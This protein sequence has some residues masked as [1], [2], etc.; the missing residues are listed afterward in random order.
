M[1]GMEL[2]IR[3]VWN[4][5]PGWLSLYTGGFLEL[6]RCVLTE[7][8]PWSPLLIGHAL[9]FTGGRGRSSEMAARPVHTTSGRF[10]A[11]SGLNT[12]RSYASQSPQ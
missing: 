5:R 12:V 8:C 4:P 3:Y 1:A 6:A 11:V 10:S 7:A 9:R 2:E